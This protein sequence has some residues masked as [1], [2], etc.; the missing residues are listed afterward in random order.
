MSERG[1]TLSQLVGERM[2]LFP[3]SGEINRK[4]DPS[5]GGAKAV[6]ERAQ[7]QYEKGSKAIDFTD[8]LSIEFD[9]WRFNL[10][11]S[12]TEPL[13]RLNVEI[14]RRRRADAREDG[15]AAEADGCLALL[16][17]AARHRCRAA[18]A[19]RAGARGDRTD[20][21]GRCRTS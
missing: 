7:K 16:T 11:A 4:L 10:R 19:A 6:L 17:P 12:N 9:Q 2:R 1:K 13:M 18:P 20:S 5:K 21:P 8:G 14:A 3:A 15:R